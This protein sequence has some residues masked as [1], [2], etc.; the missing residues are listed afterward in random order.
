MDVS[1]A[2]FAAMP[3]AARDSNTFVASSTAIGNT[4]LQV[5]HQ[6]TLYTSGDGL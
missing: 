1:V 2:D 4:L 6:D 5:I 3:A